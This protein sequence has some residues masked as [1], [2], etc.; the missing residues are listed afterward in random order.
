MPSITFDSFDKG[1]DLRRGA[2][3]SDSNVLLEALN[4]YIDDGRG[5]ITRGGLK[6]V[7]KL[8]QGS[9]GLAIFN[10]QLVTFSGDAEVVHGSTSDGITILNKRVEFTA[11]GTK[12]VTKFHKADQYQGSIYVSLTYE[13]GEIRHSYLDGNGAD[14][15]ADV[16]C[17][18]SENFSIIK[19][20]VFA[21]TT[22]GDDNV[23][24]SST[25]NGPKDWSETDDAGFIGTSTQAPGTTQVNAVD[26]FG[27]KLVVFM[28]D[29]MQVWFAD[30]DPS[31]IA[32]ERTLRNV[33]TKYP[34]SIIPVY[35][36]LF[37]ISPFG[38]R[39]VGRQQYTDNLED[40]DVG[41]PIDTLVVPT[42]KAYEDS[43][44]S[45]ATDLDVNGI[46][47]SSSGLR[48]PE[49]VY[50]GSTGQY[51][52]FVGNQAFVYT[53]SRTAKVSAWSRYDFGD[54]QPEHAI[55]LN[56]KV[57]V[58]SGDNIYLLDDDSSSDGTSYFDWSFSLSYQSNK[59]PGVT[60]QF[61]GFDVVS[62]GSAT[63]TNG[64]DSN[65]YSLQT[66]GYLVSGN[67]RPGARQ[68]CEM[69][70][71]EVSPG[72]YGNSED[73]SFRLDAITYYYE[74]LGAFI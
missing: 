47:I 28:G 34:N 48:S 31:N 32:L 27:G 52:C 71:T 41:T 62:V 51:I 67:T 11:D 59:S 70:S 23:A 14:N 24:Y 5:I 8:A 63:M 46:Q 58:R 43:L 54:I 26:E 45:I 60:K 35:R 22:N 66:Y 15:V 3:V 1:L 33:G 13:N 25:L 17:P 18:H 39:S 64:Y 6:L 55:E 57:Y 68:P 4:V 44:K 37:F 72:F 21:P 20:K 61:T 10:G 12:A 7:K 56:G 42:I 16:N 9:K 73:G 65:D 40:I 69:I 38:F 36:D 49:A 19:G 53:F 29:S 30:P 2:A 50:S 74:N